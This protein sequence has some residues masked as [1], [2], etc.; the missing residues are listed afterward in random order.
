[1]AKKSSKKN[2]E[3]KAGYFDA[4]DGRISAMVK[5]LAGDK[6]EEVLFQAEEYIEAGRY[7][8]R[9]LADALEKYKLV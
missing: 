8:E 7:P 2:T 3:H 1:M 5:Q 6:L 9:A 4:V